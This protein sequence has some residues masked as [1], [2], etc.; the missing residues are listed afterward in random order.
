MLALLSARAY[1]LEVLGMISD[2]FWGPDLKSSPLRAESVSWPMIVLSFHMVI[3]M[4]ISF[5]LM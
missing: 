3:R 4:G 5:L 2:A 1:S